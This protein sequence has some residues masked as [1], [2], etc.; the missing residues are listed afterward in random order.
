MPLF[1]I[2]GLLKPMSEGSDSVPLLMA[3]LF[4]AKAL[5]E[6]SA[7]LVSDFNRVLMFWGKKLLLLL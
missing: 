2:G 6:Y 5:V 4:S 3:S 1:F 7:N